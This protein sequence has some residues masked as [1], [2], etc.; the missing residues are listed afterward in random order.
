MILNINSDGT[1]SEHDT[2]FTARQYLSDIILDQNSNAWVCNQG[3][4]LLEGI[5]A[6]KDS[7]NY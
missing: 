4:S 6:E 2:I 5:I 3:D 1:F 7:K